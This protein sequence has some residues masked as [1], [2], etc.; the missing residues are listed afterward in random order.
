VIAES[1]GLARLM[2]GTAQFAGHY[3]LL[4]GVSAN[5]SHPDA[6]ALQILGA[7]EQA[8]IGSLDTAPVYGN[9]EQIIGASGWTGEVWTKLDPTLRPEESVIRSLESVKRSRLDVLYVHDVGHLLSL[10]RRGLAELNAL[11]GPLVDALGV[12]AYE[13]EEVLEAMSR[14]DVDVVQL[15]VNPFD[16]R[17]V[18]ALEAKQLPLECTYVGRSVFLQ[19]LLAQPEE[20]AVRA[21][22]E[23]REAIRRWQVKCRV[24]GI[25]PGEAALAWALSLPF[26]NRVIVGAESQGQLQQIVSWSQL[27]RRSDIIEAIPVEDLWPLSDPRT[28]TAI[29]RAGEE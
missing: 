24:L 29:S 13:P 11:R 19:G 21:P 10:D 16:G 3:G 22:D 4:A 5:P 1:G 12:S 9:A 2:L 6:E 23:L 20:A 7:A 14:L 8:G 15:P 18:R 27:Q 26:L 25:A 17:L 28:W